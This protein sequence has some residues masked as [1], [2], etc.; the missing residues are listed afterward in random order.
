MYIMRV[1]T[2]MPNNHPTVSS[3]LTGLWGALGVV[4]G[5]VL[6]VAPGNGQ[7]V[8]PGLLLS[9]IGA[10]LVVLVMYAGYSTDRFRVWT[11]STRGTRYMVTGHAFVRWAGPIILVLAFLELLLFLW[12]LMLT[13]E[14]L[15]QR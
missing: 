5:I 15:K 12:L 7:S 13:S 8:A 2:S 4:V 10:V 3:V 14:V 6:A 1:I 9:F 11:R